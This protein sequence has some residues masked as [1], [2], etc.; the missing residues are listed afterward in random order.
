MVNGIFRF[1]AELVESG[2]I[3]KENVLNLAA[4]I[5]EKYLNIPLVNAFQFVKNLVQGKSVKDYIIPLAVDIASM[6]VPVVGIINMVNNILKG[7][8]AL[9]TKQEIKEIGGISAVYTDKYKVFKR[10]H[11]IKL[12]NDFFDIHIC[13]HSKH[14][15][16]AKRWA[17]SDFKKQLDHKV[18][19]VLGI[20][21]EY[22]ND[23]Y[24]KRTTRFG[25]YA[26]RYYL[27]DLE[28]KWLE[29]NE[30]Y[31]TDD[32]KKLIESMYF[33]NEKDKEYRY[34]LVYLPWTSYQN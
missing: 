24:I 4:A 11:K 7:I 23:T 6:M 12:D 13:Y 30:K 14:A 3:T 21:I 9:L 31:L 20:P 27:Q 8:D 2:K 32:E 15:R 33:E 19:Q 16:D 25:K 26:E 34:A 1:C 18:Y 29:V 28:N 5:A 22:L 10:K 17:E